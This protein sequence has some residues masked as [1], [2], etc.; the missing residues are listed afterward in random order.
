MIVVDCKW[1][2]YSEWSPCSKTCGKG[3]Q[4]RTRKIERQAENGGKPCSGSNEEKRPCGTE[5]MCA[6]GM[7]GDG[8]TCGPDKDLDGYPDEGLTCKDVADERCKKDNCPTTP[9]S[10]QED[11]D[12]DGTGDACDNDA[13]NDGVANDVDNCPNSSNPSQADTDGDTVGDEC[14]NCVDISNTSQ[15][16]TDRQ[17]FNMGV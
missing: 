8:E 7:A 5:C 2:P 12:G 4:F 10:G 15:E 9:N 16:D 6:L 3:E 13:D 14:D 11:E 17:V 1:G